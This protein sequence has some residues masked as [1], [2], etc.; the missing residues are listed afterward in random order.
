MLNPIEKA[1]KASRASEKKLAG[2][3]VTVRRDSYVSDMF[4]ATVADTQIE[5]YQSDNTVTSNRSRDYII[6]VDDYLVNGVCVTPVPGDVINEVING[7]SC[8]FEVLALAGEQPYS[9]MDRSR[10]VL[11][12]HTKEVVNDYVAGS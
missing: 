6:D 7:K 3:S 4:I 1:F 12:V 2:V 9:F 5:E 8:R 11:R 10:M